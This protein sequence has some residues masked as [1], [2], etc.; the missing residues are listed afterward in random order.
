MTTAQKYL[1]MA[2]TTKDEHTKVLLRM[3]ASDRMRN[4]DAMSQIVTWL[5][6]GGESDFKI[7][8]NILMEKMLSAENSAKEIS[9]RKTV[10]VKHPI[11]QLLLEWIDMDEGKHGRMVARMLNLSK[12]C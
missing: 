12:Q 8:S 5:E 9:L 1:E 4:I 7:P 3:I 10:K 2:N 6:T 11:S